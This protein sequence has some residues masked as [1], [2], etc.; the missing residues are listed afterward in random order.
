[1]RQTKIQKEAIEQLREQVRVSSAAARSNRIWD[2]EL[3][4]KRELARS[5]VLGGR[6]GQN[7]NGWRNPYPLDD[8][9]SMLL[10]YQFGYFH[11]QSRFKIE[12]A[13]RQTG[14]DFTTQGEIAADI[15]AR[16]TDWMVAAPSE[17]QSLSS[18][19]QGK[20][21]VEAFGLMIE[22]L[23]ETREAGPQ[24]LLKSAEIVLS[25]GSRVTAVPGKPDTVRGESANVLLTE[26][27]FFENPQAT[28][29]GILPSITNSLRGGEKRLR[30]VS[31]PNGKNGKMFELFEGTGKNKERR[32]DWSRYKVTI[33]DAVL[34]GLPTDWLE[35][36]D[37]L[38]DAEG[39]AQ[40]YEV[41]FI[42]ASGV[43]LPYD[44]I[45][46]CE[47]YDASTNIPGDFWSTRT[48][49][50]VV[51]GIDFGRI[52]DPSVCWTLE[53]I[54]D[55]WWTREVLVMD[56]MPTQQQVALLEP[57]MRRASRVC[58]DYTGPG[59]GLGDLLA[60]KHG[61]YK[62]AQHKFGK[63]ELCNF[64]PALKCEI[65]PN[66]RSAMSG[67]QL[68]LPVD[69]TVREDLHAVQQ[70]VHNGNYSYSAPRTEAGHSDRCTALALANRAR[71]AGSG[72]AYMQ[73]LSRN[74]RAARR[75][76]SRSTR[77]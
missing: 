76:N 6:L 50:P 18:L 73:P 11:D 51:C 13:S 20:I 12:L 45:G 25:N 71:A 38:D 64:T 3:D 40:E 24:S 17:R 61:E 10:E 34:M 2:M 31:T 65:F 27:D 75:R 67:A 8:P 16:K 60:H 29:R 9:R 33:Y 48:G 47:H 26:F 30:C 14:K 70:K 5:H 72:P 66:L 68:R 56:N 77:Y 62:P 52:N 63:I 37:I 49:R 41:Q 22:D 35:L 36:Q 53:L 58:V 21:W 28:W 74:R 55:V 42:D 15:F 19:R 46:L 4:T 1:M 43:L 57:R 7:I 54:G 69:T 32:L 44:L 23:I 59:I 39:W